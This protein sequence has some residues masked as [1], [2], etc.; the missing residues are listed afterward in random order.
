MRT[1]FEGDRALAICLTYRR[2]RL[3]VLCQSEPPSLFT[4][5]AF[6]KAGQP[7]Y[8]LDDR[9]ATAA[10][11]S[12]QAALAKAKAYAKGLGGTRAQLNGGV[13]ILLGGALRD[14]LQ[15]VELQNRHRHLRPVFQEQPGHAQLLGD[16]TSPQHGGLLKP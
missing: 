8:Q 13:A 5:G 10:V 1:K 7:L 16:Y 15:I 14:H 11:N 2:A 6:V 3:L 9:S 4:D 12:A